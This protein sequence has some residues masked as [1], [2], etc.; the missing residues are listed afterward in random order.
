MPPPHRQLQ[1]TLARYSCVQLQHEGLIGRWQQQDS[2][3]AI[4]VVL[5]TCL[6]LISLRGHST[7]ATDSEALLI[8]TL[9]AAVHVRRHFQYPS[10]CQHVTQMRSSHSVQEG[11]HPLTGQHAANFRQLA[12]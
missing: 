6:L 12:N 8:M 1:T 7:L 9:S 10:T 4:S 3:H 2:A 5:G 11:Q